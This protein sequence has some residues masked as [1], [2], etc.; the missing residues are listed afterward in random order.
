MLATADVQAMF[1]HETRNGGPTFSRRVG[2]VNPQDSQYKSTSTCL[3]AR[4]ASEVAGHAVRNRCFD[5]CFLG[6]VVNHPVSIGHITSLDS[7]QNGHVT[8]C[9]TSFILLCGPETLNVFWHPVQVTIFSITQLTTSPYFSLLLFSPTGLS[10]LPGSRLRRGLAGFAGTLS[11]FL[12][13]SAV[14]V[15]SRAFAAAFPLGLAEGERC[16]AGPRL[17]PCPSSQPRSPQG[18]LL[19]R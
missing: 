17:F 10:G 13:S 11:L 14:I 4:Q 5:A 16:Q 19:S 1:L 8:P 6:M 12:R 3:F 9:G 2:H 7:P 18:Q 15:L